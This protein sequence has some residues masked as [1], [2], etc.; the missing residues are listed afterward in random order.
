ML[1]INFAT[2]QSITF[3]VRSPLRTT[4]LP[5]ASALSPT[6]ACTVLPRLCHSAVVT[7]NLAGCDTYSS[8]AFICHVFGAFSPSQRAFEVG[9]AIEEDLE[10]L[11]RNGE[12]ELMDV[13]SGLH[14]VAFV[15]SVGVSSRTLSRVKARRVPITPAVAS[16]LTS[17][18]LPP[19]TRPSLAPTTPCQNCGTWPRHLPPLPLPPSTRNFGNNSQHNKR[20]SS[21]LLLPLARPQPLPLQTTLHSNNPSLR[22][23][24]GQEVTLHTAV[25]RTGKRAN[26]LC[27]SSYSTTSSFLVLL[28]LGSNGVV[29]LLLRP[30]HQPSQLLQLA[31]WRSSSTPIHS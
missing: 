18:S 29:R 1:C 10:R 7:L 14:L 9:H 16:L 19:R 3:D 22:S 4:P 24:L 17:S 13:A 26:T 28:C 31:Q 5:P 20:L 6:Y 12:E 8:K 25:L 21:T 11:Q 30:L 27:S 2:N 23:Q 15:L